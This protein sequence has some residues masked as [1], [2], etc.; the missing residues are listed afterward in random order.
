MKAE[1]IIVISRKER[2]INGAKLILK[3]IKQDGFECQIIFIEDYFVIYN[4]KRDKRKKKIFYFLTNVED[5]KKCAKN[6]LQEGHVV[7]NKKY[8][9][10]KRSK[11]YLQMSIKQSGVNVPKSVCYKNNSKDFH[12]MNFPFYIKSQQ[13]ASTVLR[14]VNKKLLKE[15]LCKNQEKKQY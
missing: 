6:A 1:I 13:Q 8:L 5:V 2:F 10:K 9:F 12:G 14:V 15:I 7:V 11:F 3:Q 4:G